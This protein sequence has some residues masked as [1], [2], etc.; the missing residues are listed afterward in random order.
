MGAKAA[1]GSVE[2]LAFL[3]KAFK[4]YDA[5]YTM[6]PPRMDVKNWKEWIANIGKGY[7]RAIQAAGVK[8]VVNLSS[9]GAHMPTGCGPVSGLHFAEE[10]LHSLTGVDILHLR[11]GYFIRICL[12]PLA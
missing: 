1:V 4:G 9:V 7:A 6:I 11:P 8:K 3:E 10:A 12:A 5:L 2:D